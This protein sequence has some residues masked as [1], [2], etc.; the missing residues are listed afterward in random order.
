MQTPG[1]DDEMIIT[2]SNK[3]RAYS[4]ARFYMDDDLVEIV[5]TGELPDKAPAGQS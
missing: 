4:K 1:Y 5:L 3:S 2:N